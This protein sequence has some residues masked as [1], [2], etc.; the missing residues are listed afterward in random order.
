MKDISRITDQLYIGAWNS[1]IDETEIDRLGVD[2]IISTIFY[3]PRHLANH[4]IE[5]VWLP[6]F[7][8]KFL[9]I[10]MK[11]LKRGAGI[12]KEFLDE[13]KNVLVYCKEGRHRSV[14]MT[15]AILI[16]QGFSAKEAVELIK[17]QRMIADPDVEYIRRRINRYEQLNS[18]P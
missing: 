7:D 12:A 18:K 11:M 15:A 5:V 8:H 17:R 4:S 16:N 3:L 13:G 1:G 14:A 10:P 9:P 2:L 6:S